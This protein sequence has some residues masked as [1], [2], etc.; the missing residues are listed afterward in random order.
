M[1]K[2]IIT[3]IL[4]LLLVVSIAGNVYQIN[5][6]NSKIYSLDNCNVEKNDL[7]SD[8]DEKENLLTANSEKIVSLEMEMTDLQSEIETIKNNSFSIETAST[9][10]EEP[11]S[12]EDTKSSS[13]PFSGM[14]Y[15]ELG[16]IDTT[17]FTDADW[18]NYLTACQ[19]AQAEL[20]KNKPA[21]EKQPWTGKPFEEMTQEELNAIDTKTL[22]KEDK[23]R[24][25]KRYDE[26]IVE[27]LAEFDQQNQNSG[28]TTTPAP[29][30]DDAKWANPPEKETPVADGWKCY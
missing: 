14:T 2:K 11:E 8:L 29:S 18:N 4:G 28:N 23:D 26:T 9:T 13:N 7:L 15:D 20:D 17:N 21:T 25:V 5:L 30:G 27:K 19:E 6:L 3:L 16:A 10:P 22:T 12:T 1:K 24:W